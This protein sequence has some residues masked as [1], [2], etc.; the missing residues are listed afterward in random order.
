MIKSKFYLHMNVCS[1]FIHNHYESLK[2]RTN[3]QQVNGKTNSGT[4]YDEI[5]FTDKK[6]AL[7]PQKSMG[8]LEYI[9]LS[10]RSQPEKATN[11]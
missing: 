8:N 11:V 9:L 7:K 6:E 1:S 10:E 4:P 2:T 3:L 5:R